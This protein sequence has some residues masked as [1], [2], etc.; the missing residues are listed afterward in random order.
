M[1][2]LPKWVIPDKFPALF[3][4]DSATVI[5]MTAKLYG[6]MNGLIDDYNT[7]VERIN[8]EIEAFEVS[9]T[10]DYDTFII[11][12][13]QEFQDFIDTIELKVKAQDKTITDKFNDQNEVLINSVKAQDA[14][15][16]NAIS[17]QNLVIS[18]AVDY[19][20]LNLVQSL[21]SVID[22]MKDNGEFSAEVEKVFNGLVNDVTVL[23]NRVNTLTA[24]PEGS[25]VGDAELIDIRNGK[26][27]K[28]YTTAG[29]A[30]RGQFGEVSERIGNITEIT[31]N[32]ANI[33]T[34]RLG[35]IWNTYPDAN[36]ACLYVDVLPNTTY[37]V[38]FDGG[39]FEGI[40]L[41]EKSSSESTTDIRNTAL[42]NNTTFTTHENTN[43]VVVSF[44]KTNVSKTDF[45]HF[46]IQIEENNFVTPYLPHEVAS[47]KFVRDCVIDYVTPEMFGAYGDG[48]HDDYEAIKTA[49]GT[50]RKVVFTANKKYY[51]SKTLLMGGKPVYLDGNNCT[52]LSGATTR[53]FSVSVANHS[54]GIESTEHRVTIKNFKI[55]CINV[56][57]GL[58]VLSARQSV[59]ENLTFIN[60][61]K[62][63]VYYESG[64]ENTFKDIYVYG[65]APYCVGFL[66]DG[67]DSTFEN[68]YGY[69]V[70]IFVRTSGT[71][72]YNNLH[73][74]I[75][76]ASRYENSIFFDIQSG[77]QRINSCF[78]DTYR[79]CLVVRNQSS[80]I[81][82]N[83][84]YVFIN[85]NVISAG[86]CYFFYYTDA[87]NSF[88]A[89]VASG[90]LNGNTAMTC[91]FTNEDSFKGKKSDLLVAWHFNM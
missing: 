80:Y 13:R 79:R 70:D 49:M 27:G 52:I 5:E 18:D 78:F 33:T 9:M 42:V 48:E 64:Y 91:N 88:N 31:K 65:I 37:S 83:D 72:V 89:V 41:V 22:D 76:T 55:D 44:N 63:A 24:L 39:D 25:T 38:S 20:K 12:M 40:Y 68:L 14:K 10:K 21:N 61:R 54:H 81:L 3:D 84:V 86:E 69:D 34:I 85:P 30:V 45:N 47:D 67:G 71:N 90:Y 50:G 35:E 60:V 28:V 58:E 29:E 62:T 36:R 73:A 11:S 56:E 23:N 1:V 87:L 82:L 6:A 43:V 15:I 19:M 2:K 46:W 16:A 4:H 75:H 57:T 74:W 77:N 66:V 51:V 8:A 32:L 17:Q 59:F 53:V 26:N 7:F